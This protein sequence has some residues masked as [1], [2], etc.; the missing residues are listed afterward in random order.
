MIFNKLELV[1][2]IINE[3]RIRIICICEYI[4][5]LIFDFFFNALLYSDEVVSHKYHNNGE[6]DSLVSIS[7]S[8]ISN[9][10]TSIVCYYVEYSKG[11]ER[12]IEEI[13]EIK[14]E[15]RY[16]YAFK[17]FLRYMK[18]KLL[19][20]IMA[21]IVLIGV[22]FYYLL[23]F[24]MIYNKSQISLLVNYL[25]SLIESFLTSLAITLVIVITRQIG[26]HY[27]NCY[28]YNT[29]KFINEKF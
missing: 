24:C 21:E 5:S 2:L 23:I 15:Y 3:N 4:I 1:S 12:R 13:I 22:C 8:I 28:L 10:I 29:S 25:Y 27:S 26:I 6:L 19:F 16:I 11:I 14:I 18:C 9:I 7:L 20:F 17:K